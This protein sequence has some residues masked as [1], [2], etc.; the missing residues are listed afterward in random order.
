[1]RKLHF[2]HPGEILRTE[3]LDEM[4]LSCPGV[5]VFGN[6]RADGFGGWG[7]GAAVNGLL[8]SN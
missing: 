5:T 8:L 7:G 6:S 2:P 3:F 1:M 4:N